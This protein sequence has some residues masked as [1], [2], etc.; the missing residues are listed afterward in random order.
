MKIL[1]KTFYRKRKTIYSFL[2]KRITMNFIYFLWFNIW[3][4]K[5]IIGWQ[6]E[7]AKRLKVKSLI[8]TYIYRYINYHN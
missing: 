4:E 8:T 5:R 2:L 3:N 1:Y 6:F 7:T